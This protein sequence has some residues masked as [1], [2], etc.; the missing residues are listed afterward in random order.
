V[1]HLGCARIAG[2]PRG[3]F[4]LLPALDQAGDQNLAA[5]PEDAAGRERRPL[6]VLG[7]DHP[8]RRIP[9][10]P[11]LVLA[12]VVSIMP[13]VLAAA[14][15]LD[16]LGVATDVVLLTS[17]GLAFRAMRARRGFGDGSEVVLDALFPKDRAAPLVT[18]V[19]GHP[20]TLT[21]LAGVTAKPIITL[22]VDD[23]GQAGNVDDLYQNLGIDVATIVGAG[24]DLVDEGDAHC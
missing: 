5:V 8:L 19:D 9:D 15:E 22:G 4:E 1:D 24:S 16:R 18:V 10:A 13:E 2:A 11:D 3:H 14:D 23:F 7:G 21:F 12:G 6:E 17:P 20:H